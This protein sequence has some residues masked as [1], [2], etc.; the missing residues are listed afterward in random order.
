MCRVK[1][2]MLT[3]ISGF[4]SVSLD[5]EGLRGAPCILTQKIMDKAIF[6]LPS[7]HV[8]LGLTCEKVDLLTN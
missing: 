1:C 5:P 2:H 4:G 3:Q 7:P 8:T 6:L